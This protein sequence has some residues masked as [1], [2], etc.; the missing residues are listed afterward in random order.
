MVSGGTPAW[1][2]SAGRKSQNKQRNSFEQIGFATELLSHSWPGEGIAQLYTAME[3]HRTA[4]ISEG[5]VRRRHAVEW[6]G[7]TSNRKGIA[8]NR[9]GIARRRSELISNGIE[10]RRYARQRKREEWNHDESQRN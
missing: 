10:Y 8:W 5:Y 1:G 6:Q 9:D 7:V 2:D 4:K 3:L